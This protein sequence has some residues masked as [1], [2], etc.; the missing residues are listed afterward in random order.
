MCNLNEPELEHL[1]KH[2]IGPLLL[3]GQNSRTTLYGEELELT[4]EEYDTLYLL[5]CRENTPLN[6]EQLYSAAWDKMDGENARKAA[7]EGIMSVVRLINNRGR[8]AIRIE[9]IDENS[10]VFRDIEKSAPQEQPKNNRNTKRWFYGI[11]AAAAM[12]G[13]ALVRWVWTG[14][15]ASI[16]DGAVPLAQTPAQIGVQVRFPEIADITLQSDG[17]VAEV[18]LI[19][20]ADNNCRLVFKII[21]SQ[22]EELLY[23]SQMVDPGEEIESIVL[24]QPLQQGTYEAVMH[25]IAYMPESASE[26]DATAKPFQ[27][28]VT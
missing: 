22:T 20:P 21:L 16:D 19:N 9:V 27:L 28:I 5:A 18:N 24:D 12:V 10:F 6:F 11:A 23:R 4:E 14:N 3:D 17:S 7:R 15:T 1:L 26:M 2:R 8:S 13:V 25:I